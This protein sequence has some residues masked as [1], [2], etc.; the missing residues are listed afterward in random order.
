VR[1]LRQAPRISGTSQ[2]IGTIAVNA[3]TLRS[4]YEHAQRQQTCCAA[5]VSLRLVD[6]ASIGRLKI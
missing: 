3:H 2:I 6:L 4:D 5:S 1:G